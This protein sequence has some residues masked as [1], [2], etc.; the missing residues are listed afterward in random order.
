M[1]PRKKVKGD[2]T[3]IKPLFKDPKSANG[4]EEDFDEEVEANQTENTE[5][6]VSQIQR[7]REVKNP[8]IN[9]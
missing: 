5:N 6:K 1:Q 8:P 4:K 2:S 9:Q 3:N 7:N